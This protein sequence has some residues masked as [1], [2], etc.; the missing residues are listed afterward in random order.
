VSS[1]CIRLTNEN[2]IDLF[3]RVQVGAKVIVLP[4]SA[5]PTREA[6]SP[7][8]APQPHERVSLNNEPM[9]GVY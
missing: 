6:K 7:A 9:Q 2:V 3:S 8:P 4:A 5:A 1:G